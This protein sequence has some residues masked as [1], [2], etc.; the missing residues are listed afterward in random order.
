MC[1][2]VWLTAIACACVNHCERGKSK[3][4][5]N[6][7]QEFTGHKSLKHTMH[8]STCSLFFL[9]NNSSLRRALRFKARGTDWLTEDRHE[10]DWSGLKMSVLRLTAWESTGKQKNK[11]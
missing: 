11:E 4:V 2:C 9:H 10:N 8:Y 5:S 3:C 1:V 6:D 7:L